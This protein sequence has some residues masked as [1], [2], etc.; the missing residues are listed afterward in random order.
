MIK[1]REF[2][3]ELLSPFI[4]LPLLEFSFEGGSHTKQ[5]AEF[6]KLFFYNLFLSEP[7]NACIDIMEINFGFSVDSIAGI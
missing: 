3:N 1:P 2:F 4:F 5:G 7:Q 6:L